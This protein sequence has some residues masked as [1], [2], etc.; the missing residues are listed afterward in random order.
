MKSRNS[1]QMMKL[2]MSL[3]FVLVSIVASAEDEDPGGGLDNPGGPTGAVPLDAGLTA[4]LVAG[5]GYG[6][7]KAYDFKKKRKADK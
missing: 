5:A 4:L 1:K 7:K 2:T 3:I 6:A